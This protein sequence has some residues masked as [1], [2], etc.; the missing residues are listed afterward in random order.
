[1]EKKFGVKIWQGKGKFKHLFH[2]FGPDGSRAKASEIIGTVLAD[3]VR[4]EGHAK[5]N[6]QVLGA[7]GARLE[8]IRE[9]TQAIISL[10]D[11]G[12]FYFYGMQK[13][14][15]RAVK[16]VKKL[17]EDLEEIDLRPHQETEGVG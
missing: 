16:L 14:V 5:T 3:S 15:E 17:Q 2:I 8:K 11:D 7:G 13:N 9:K 1:M 12:H 10:S 4:L 6:P